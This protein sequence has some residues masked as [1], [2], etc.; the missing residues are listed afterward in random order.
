MARQGEW[1]AGRSEG[2]AAGLERKQ[3]KKEKLC[4]AVGAALLLSYHIQ[5]ITYLSSLSLLACHSHHTLTKTSKKA[6]GPNAI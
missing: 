3:H 5:L 1:P 4:W 2:A 6:T